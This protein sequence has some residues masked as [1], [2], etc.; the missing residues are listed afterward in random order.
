MDFSDIDEVGQYSSTLS[1]D[2]WDPAA[3][4]EWAFKE[5]LAAR[6][7]QTLKKLEEDKLKTPRDSLNFV[8]A[9]TSGDSNR[10]G[11]TGAGTTARIPQKSA[12]ERIMAGLDRRSNSPQLQSSLKRK[13]RFDS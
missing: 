12:A 7:Q 13:S 6:Q 8:P 2:V 1:K 4:P 3:F 11:A 5:K 9:S 10:S